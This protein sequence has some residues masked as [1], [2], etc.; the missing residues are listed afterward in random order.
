MEGIL[1]KRSPALLF[2][3]A[4]ARRSAWYRP[5]TVQVVTGNA[6]SLE[7]R[8]LRQV[9]N[10]SSQHSPEPDARYAERWLTILCRKGGVRSH[11][12]QEVVVRWVASERRDGQAV[13]GVGQE[14]KRVVVHLQ[15]AVPHFIVSR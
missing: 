7:V 11:R 12:G 4:A 1:Q 3:S 9:F 13:T 14:G 8:I 2:A 5:T 10:H 6:T 15:E